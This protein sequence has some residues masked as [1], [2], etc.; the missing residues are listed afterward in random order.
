MLDVF[1][2]QRSRSKNE[3]LLAYS[4]SHESPH[5]RYRLNDASIGLKRR[6]FALPS[7]EITIETRNT[8]RN[9]LYNWLKYD[10]FTK[11]HHKVK[12]IFLLRNY[13][14]KE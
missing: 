2:I 13:V 9:N 5:H 11:Q 1:E 10:F 8:K 3:H 6:S 7:I 4:L 12:N 14:F